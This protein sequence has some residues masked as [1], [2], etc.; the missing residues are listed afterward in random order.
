MEP[1]AKCKNFIESN[2][3][4]LNKTMK[5]IT[6]LLW[7]L[8]TLLT[9]AQTPKF[10]SVKLIGEIKRQRQ[11]GKFSVSSYEKSPIPLENQSEINK[12]LEKYCIPAEAKGQIRLKLSSLGL[13]KEWLYYRDANTEILEK[14]NKII[15]KNQPITAVTVAQHPFSK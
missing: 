3:E 4:I 5:K 6:F 14:V 2:A 1:R 15:I 9:N 13:N 7:C 12:H 8:T 11:Y 10:E